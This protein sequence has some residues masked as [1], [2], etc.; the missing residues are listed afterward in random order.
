MVVLL[1]VDCSLILAESAFSVTRVLSTLDKAFVLSCAIDGNSNL[2]M[3]KNKVI[4]MK[5]NK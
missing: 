3:A 1:G 4:V 2:M 5:P